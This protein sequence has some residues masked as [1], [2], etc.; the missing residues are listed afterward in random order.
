[1]PTGTLDTRFSW[2]LEHSFDYH[3]SCS[4]AFIFSP[5]IVRHNLHKIK[6]ADSQRCSSRG[7]YDLM[8]KKRAPNLSDGWCLK[9]YGIKFLYFVINEDTESQ[10]RGDTGDPG[11]LTP[12]SVL[13]ALPPQHPL[14]CWGGSLLS[15][16]AGSHSGYQVRS[17]LSLGIT[18]LPLSGASELLLE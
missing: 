18:Q 8:G 10:T 1:M 14:D 7:V 2:F 13:P 16:P 5:A 6:F 15:Q 17:C 12:S 11:S 4:L 3:I 9:V